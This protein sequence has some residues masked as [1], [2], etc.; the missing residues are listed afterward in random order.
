MQDAIQKRQEALKAEIRD[1]KETIRL[2]TDSDTVFR[3]IPS[4]PHERGI[5][6]FRRRCVSTS[7]SSEGSLCEHRGTKLIHFDSNKG[8]RQVHR[9]KC[10]GH[11]AKGSVVYAGVDMTTGELLAI[12]E[13]TLKCAVSNENYPIQE[14]ID[15]H[16]AMKQI[17]SLEQELNHLYKLHHPNLVHYL[18]IKYLQ[19]NNNVVIYILQEF[20]VC[21][22]IFYNSVHI[23]KKMCNIYICILRNYKNIVFSIVILIVCKSRLEPHARSS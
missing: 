12:T 1:R 14:A 8:E 15:I 21:K 2:A 13:W 9:G 6:R 18:N 16:H 17:A 11:S 7:E 5:S 23:Y 4:S 19:N 3:S 20:V 10:L 22:N